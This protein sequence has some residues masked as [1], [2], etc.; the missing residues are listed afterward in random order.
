MKTEFITKAYNQYFKVPSISMAGGLTFSNNDVILVDD[1]AIEIFGNSPDNVAYIIR[2]FGYPFH[3][4][5]GYKN[6]AEYHLTTPMEDVYLWLLL[7]PYCTFGVTLPKSLFDEQMLISYLEVSGHDVTEQKKT[8]DKQLHK[9][10]DALKQALKD[11]LRPVTIRDHAFNILGPVDDFEMEPLPTREL[12]WAGLYEVAKIY[13]SKDAF[14]AFHKMLYYIV[15]HSEGD[16]VEN[17]NNVIVMLEDA[18]KSREQK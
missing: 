13:E 18:K 6:M 14:D 1:Y 4:T 9:M 12:A 7:K 16:L 5:D 3:G 2:R 11:L 10:R 17:T 8:Y 15:N